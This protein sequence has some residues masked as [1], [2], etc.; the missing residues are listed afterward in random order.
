M[1]LDDILSERV[2]RCACKKD[3]IMKPEITFFGEVLP[4]KFFKTVEKDV[5]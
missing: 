4:D 5:S 2:P 1:C 3:G